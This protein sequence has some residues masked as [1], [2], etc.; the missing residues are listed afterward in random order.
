[1]LRVILID[2]MLVDKHNEENVN[3]WAAHQQTAF[4]IQY[5]YTIRYTLKIP[6]KLLKPYHILINHKISIKYKYSK[7]I[8]IITLY[9]S[10]YIYV[11]FGSQW[12]TVTT[13]SP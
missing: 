13:L 8:N 5:S 2:W 4:T 7:Y 11:G 6:E 12:R 10:Q 3:Q 9:H 1:M